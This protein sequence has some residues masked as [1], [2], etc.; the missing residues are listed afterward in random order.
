MK[1]CAISDLHGYLPEIKPCDILLI[2]GD[3]S[4]VDIQ[5]NKPK[6]KE[7]LEDTFAKWIRSLPVEK[8]FLIA[9]N[10]DSYFENCSQG[11]LL[12]FQ[13]ACCNLIYLENEVGYYYDENAQLWSIFGTPYCHTFG[14]WPFMRSEEF[15]IE[16]FSKIP[17][18]VDIIITH[19]PPFA[20]G[21]TDVI[22]DAPVHRI[23]HV[24]LNEHLG[25]QPLRSV[26]EKTKY[27]LHVCGHIHSGDH[28]Y[29]EGWK[30]VNVSYLD[31][32]YQPKYSPFYIELE[33]PNVV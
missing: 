24:R 33:K 25:N 6:M 1:V 11:A 12:S 21:D 22:L 32:Y 3:I 14:N 23:G 10:H 29:N 27:K 13:Q 2:A 5:F 19:D 18:E 28:I 7:W 17:E 9:G 26:L 8:V 31:E 30:S 15:M 20:C 4:P 16:K